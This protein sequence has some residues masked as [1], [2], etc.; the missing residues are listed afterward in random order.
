MHEQ[1]NQ[2]A[3]LMKNFL[4]L[5]LLS[6][7]IV[8]CGF[9]GEFQTITVE[10]RYSLDVPKELTTTTEM[11]AEASLQYMNVIR[12]FYVLVID[13]PIDEFDKA[14]RENELENV[15]TMDEEGYSS[16]VTSGIKDGLSNL[17]EEVPVKAKINGMPSIIHKFSGHINDIDV[18]YNFGVYRGQKNYYQVLT[19]T[20]KDHKEKYSPEMEKIIRSLKE[21]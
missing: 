8:S 2:K 12:E 5:F 19:W 15:V 16:L 7:I 9:S 11:H 10:G 3:S 13:E 1:Q 20:M 17:E 6:V 21:L 14:V 4:S 18:Y